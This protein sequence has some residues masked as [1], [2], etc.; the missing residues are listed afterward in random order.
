MNNNNTYEKDGIIDLTIIRTRIIRCSLIR[1]YE[2]SYIY[3][4]ENIG[5]I[6]YRE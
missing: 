6:M 4:L 1:V 3:V 2:Y 5:N